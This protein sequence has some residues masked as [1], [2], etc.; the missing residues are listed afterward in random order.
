MDAD[1][2]DCNSATDASVRPK[3]GHSEAVLKFLKGLISS[4]PK[5]KMN[6]HIVAG[7]HDVRNGQITG[8]TNGDKEAPIKKMR[9][10]QR[11]HGG[12]NE[13]RMAYMER[14]SA[15]TGK[16]LAVSAEQVSIFLTAGMRTSSHFSSSTKY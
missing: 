1:D 16:Q 12:P 14:H 11:F 7:V 2:S 9:T 3:P 5:S 8:R 4:K 10:L 15:L 6:G 13:D